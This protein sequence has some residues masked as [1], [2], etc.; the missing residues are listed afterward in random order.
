[1]FKLTGWLLCFLFCN[2]CAYATCPVWPPARAE[3]EIARLKQQI[4]R[5]NDA[6]WQEGKSQVS[7]G[8]YD[9]LS[10]RLTH[11]EH[12]FGH[13]T[14]A[15]IATPPI[16]GT[17]PHPVAHTGVRKLED[18]KAL[19][20]W[21]TKKRDLWVQPKVDG[22]AVTLI[23]R[24]GELVQAISRGNGLAGEDWTAKV[25][26]IP[27][28]PAHVDGALQNSVLQGELFL[29]RGKHIQQ[30]MG[31]MNARAKVAGALMQR[32]QSPLL[33]EIALFVWAWPDG[34]A[35]MKKRLQLLNDAGFTLASRYSLPVDDADDVEAIRSRWFTSSL[36]FVTDGVV[37]R[38]GQEPEGHRWLPGQND[39]AVAWKYPPAEQVTEVKNIQFTIGRSGKI[40]V[41][42]QLEPVQLDDKRV[43][44]VNIGSVR[45]WNELDIAPG[46]QVQISLAGQGI[47]RID[48]VAWRNLTRKKPTPPPSHF[49]ALTCFY[50]VPECSEQ[51]L[52]RLVWVSSPDALDMDGVGDAFWRTLH[53]AHRFEHL[54]SWLALTPQQLQ[55]TP[56]ISAHN[57]MKLWHQFNLARDRPFIRWVIALGTPLPQSALKATGDH[58]WQQLLARNEQQWQQLPG[59]GGQKAKNLVTFI[60]HPRIQAV[61]LWLA[62]QGIAG[63]VNPD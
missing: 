37:I 54:F 61:T 22:V 49:N 32:A 47:P 4:A 43:Q 14:S 8:V 48:G 13:P 12:C 55:N 59:I 11:W 63:F 36:P 29:L 52:A 7:D 42:A 60:H 58:H 24:N 17:V 21:M 57:G 38:T 39:G 18:K 25:R 15:D 51:F 20:Q 1:M 28:V 16:S 62:S 44:R 41:V 56:G 9:Q 46:D 34:P 30:K 19:A 31:G 40:A 5:W 3:Q 50:A 26:Q 6:Y 53:Q 35:E 10:A 45:R 2:G 27:S 23:Y 33:N